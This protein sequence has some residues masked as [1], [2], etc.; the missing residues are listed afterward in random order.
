MFSFPSHRTGGGKGS[1]ERRKV[2]S[3]TRKK[4]G[5]GVWGSG[6][7]EGNEGMGVGVTG[8]VGLHTQACMRVWEACG[9]RG[10]GGGGA[11]TR[12]QGYG[13]RTQRRPGRRD[14]RNEK[15]K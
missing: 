6:V 3:Q 1:G 11:S 14:K 4:D 10:K 9:G 5:V 8:R 13:Y 12:G 7:N 15:N 2:D